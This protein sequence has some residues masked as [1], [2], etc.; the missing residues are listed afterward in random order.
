MKQLL[1]CMS[2]LLFLG[3]APA[4]ADSMSEIP[5]SNR[6]KILPYSA[7][8]VYTV[9]TKYGYQTSIVFEHSE[10]IKTVSV[11]DRSMWQIIPSANRIFIRPMDDDLAT[12]MTVITNMREYNF[13]I[14]SVAEDQTNNVYVIQFRYPDNASKNDMTLNDGE[15]PSNP[16]AQKPS[17][18][19]TI[20]PMDT[21]R[22][23][24]LNENY[25][26]TGPDELAPM[27]VY[28]DGKNTYVIYNVMPT[29]TPKPIVTSTAGKSAMAR[30]DVSGNKI[31]IHTVVSGF[32][33][34]SPKGKITVYNELFHP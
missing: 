16:V 23:Q 31:I 6:I 8:D 24:E 22:S 21:Q 5:A 33:L 12:N 15:M 32:V 25:S 19:I 9:P 28:D 2:A 20:P 27:Q 18:P 29:P 13:D 1:Y 10:E 26:Y 7:S 3:I 4:Q 30:H 17:T 34:K 11:G 14:K